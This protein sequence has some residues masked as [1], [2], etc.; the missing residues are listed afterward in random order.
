MISF[1]SWHLVWSA[2]LGVHYSR[3]TKRPT[4]HF[5]I[6]AAASRSDRLWF[7]AAGLCSF[8]QAATFPTAS[9]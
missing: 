6:T 3:G 2:A 5:A 4:E 7:L 8:G 1:S 9:N